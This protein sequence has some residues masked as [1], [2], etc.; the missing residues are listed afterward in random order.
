M[1]DLLI[2]ENGITR[3]AR[4]GQESKA[5]GGGQTSSSKQVHFYAHYTRHLFAPVVPAIPKK[6][7]SRTRSYGSKIVEDRSER[8]YDPSIV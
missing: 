3:A 1:A 4:Q 8:K 2:E 7:K 5:R 6:P